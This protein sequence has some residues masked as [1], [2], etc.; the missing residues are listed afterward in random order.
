MRFHVSELDGIIWVWDSLMRVPLT[1]GPDEVRWE[2]P[3]KDAAQEV[4][5][6]MNQRVEHPELTRADGRPVNGWELLNA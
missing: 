4:C 3:A 6:I 1:T 2:F 5:D